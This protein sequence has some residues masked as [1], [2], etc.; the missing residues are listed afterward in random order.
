V[1]GIVL[2]ALPF[3][4]LH[5]QQYAGSWQHVFAVFLAGAVFGYV[6]H[7]TKSTATAAVMHAGYNSTFVFFLIL[8]QW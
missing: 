6:R 4:L 2:A 7:R 5:W 3:A 1:G 8:R